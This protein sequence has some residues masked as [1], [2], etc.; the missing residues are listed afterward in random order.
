MTGYIVRRL[1]VAVIIT[2]GIAAIT[3]AILHYLAPSP[4]YDVLGTKAQPAVVTAWNRS[5]GYDR[6]EVAQFLTYFGHLLHLNFG[7]SYKL[8]QTVS[9]LFKENLG[10]SAYLSGAALVLSLLIAIP[11]GILQAVRRNS[12]E[13]YT[14][15]TINFVL[16]SMPSFFLGLIL[17][18]IF[19]LD[20]NIFPPGVSDNITTTWGAITHPNQL[21]LPIVTLTV[22]NIASFSRY[23]RS[24]T[25]DNLAQDYIRLARAKGLSQRAVLFRHLLRNACLP[26]ITL[27]GLSIPTLLAGN[28]LIEVLFNYQGLGLLFYNA[29]QNNDYNIMLA[30]TILGG[31]FTVLG[32]LIADIFTAAADPMIRFD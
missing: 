30:Y 23:M 18:Q 5:H 24:S 19:A 4:V 8:S 11:L 9:A 12:I 25:L 22:I 26:M 17:I 7:Y 10:R 1:G 2:I 29:L 15:T 32:N 14:L 16:Y 6:S 31:V 28:L 20:L 27:V 21:F 13:D 3:F